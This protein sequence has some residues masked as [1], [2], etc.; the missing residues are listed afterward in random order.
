MAL[1][2]CPFC[3]EMFEAGEETSCPLCG[4]ALTEFSKLPPSHEAQA[5]DE[6]DI[7]V[8]PELERLP[9]TYM[10]RGKGIL[11][12]LGAAG[13]G[14]F[15]L[16]WIHMSLPYELAI[17]GFDIARGRLGWV[18]ASGIA[19]FVF[20]PTVLSRRS[21]LQMRGARVA[22]AFLAA[23]PGLTVTILLA[24]PPHG[25]L[26]PLRFSYGWPFWATL[27]VS[28]AAIAFSI[29][30]GGRID[31]IVVSRGTSKGHDLH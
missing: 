31:D 21:I 26:V 3:R 10:G 2:A 12:L 11:A 30:L 13:L 5:L 16:P 29:R 14:L 7:P 22:A 18:W 17:T 9:S 27:L 20:L 23:I 1:V 6:D 4:V 24:R 19:W 28:I 15:F 25:G 8:A